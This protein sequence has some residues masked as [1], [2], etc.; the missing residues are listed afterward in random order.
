MLNLQYNPFM[1]QIA[2]T[3]GRRKTTTNC[4]DVAAGGRNVGVP[5][6]QDDNG[7]PKNEIIEKYEMNFENFLDLLN[8]MSPRSPVQLK[9]HYAFKLYGQLNRL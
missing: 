5:V 8:V 7:Y 6:D 9:A 2:R 3:F 4:N 1:D